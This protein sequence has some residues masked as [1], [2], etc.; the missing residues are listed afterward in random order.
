MAT[1]ECFSIP[2]L[3][4]WF[5]SNDHNPAHFH[6]KKEGTW[7]VRVFFLEASS[8]MFEAV[9]GDK[10]FSAKDRRALEAMVETCRDKILKEWEEKVKSS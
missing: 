2:G 8:N 7:E 3:K 4:L 1:L 9:W 10:A 6:A 5:W